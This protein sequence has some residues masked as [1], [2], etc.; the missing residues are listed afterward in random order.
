MK[1]IVGL[2]NPG[3][4]YERTRHNAGFLVV[5]ELARRRAPGGAPRGRFHALTYDATL[6]AGDE[7]A[8]ALLLKPTTY[9]NRSGLAVAEAVRFYKL[10]P[11]EDLLVIVDDVDLPAGSIRLR[12]GGGTGGHNG[13]ADIE[14]RLG[15]GGYARL[16]VGVGREGVRRRPGDVLARFSDDEWAAVAPAI[17]RA[18]DAA[19]DWAVAG[20]VHA[21]NT[22]N[23][24][25]RPG[26]AAR[27]D[28]PETHPPGPGDAGA[29]GET[30]KDRS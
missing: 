12:A 17:E 8:R 9:M 19:E 24:P 29:S 18:A 22:F 11:A 3:P 21:M 25:E 4:E 10:A 23:A 6:R 15:T 2:G 28:R 14:Q 30:S 7:S 20:V 16:R 27:Q 5:D 13:L 26:R 1:V